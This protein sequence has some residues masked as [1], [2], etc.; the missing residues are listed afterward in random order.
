MKNLNALL[1]QYKTLSIAK[2]IRDEES[3]K[4][5]LIR[6]MIEKVWGYE[7]G[8]GSERYKT[9]VELPQIGSKVNHSRCDFLLKT[10]D[11]D[12]V[13]EAKAAGESV[14][15]PKHIAETA[16]Y[17]LN[18]H[19]E[20][21]ILTNGRVWSFFLA[22]D[23]NVMEKAPFKRIEFDKITDDEKKFLLIL[24]RPG[25]DLEKIRAEYE[26]GRKKAKEQELLEKIENIIIEKRKTISTDVKKEIIKMVEPDCTQVSAQKLAYYENFF[27]AA[28]MGIAEREKNKYRKEVEEEMARYVNKVEIE[29]QAIYNMVLGLLVDEYDTS[30]IK[31]SDFDSGTLAKIHFNGQNSGQPILWISGKIVN[32]KYRFDGVCFPLPN[33]RQGDLIPLL[34][35]KDILNLRN[36]IREEARISFAGPRWKDAKVASQKLEESVKESAVSD[37]TPEG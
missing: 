35:P 7:W 32:N 15:D 4:M 17:V 23:K 31:M 30:L 18:L 27:G 14:D 11:F 22:D 6:P 36:Q 19:A 24:K 5:Y 13:I 33:G 12:V 25:C 8:A 34:N 28:L 26:E 21:G 20:L 10:A 2:E 9:E 16:S 3:V 1:E 29:E 37:G